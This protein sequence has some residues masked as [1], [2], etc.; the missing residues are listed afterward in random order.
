MKNLIVYYSKYGA[1]EKCVEIMKSA[2]SGE[3]TAVN[4]R[5]GKAPELDSFDRIIIGSN[6][7]AGRINKKVRTLCFN[8]ADAILEKEFALFL[9]CL[10]PE[11][12]AQDLF[13]KNFPPVLAEKAGARAVLGGALFFEKMNPVERFILKKIAGSDQNIDKIDPQQIERFVSGIEA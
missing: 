4:L 13:E 7:H 5:D 9:C 10:T 12:E 8:S 11:E 3:T 6:I 1:G 2:I